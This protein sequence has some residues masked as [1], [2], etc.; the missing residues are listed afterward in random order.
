MLKKMFNS[1]TSII[2]IKSAEDGR[3]V[4]VNPAFTKVIGYTKEEVEGK[5][6]EELNILLDDKYT[7]KML[8]ELQKSGK[9]K[10]AEYKVVIKSGDI[11]D[12]VFSSQ[13]IEYKDE[14]YIITV[15]TDITRQKNIEKEMAYQSRL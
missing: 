7:E 15:M 4:D 14:K 12:V 1:D 9:Y 6:P 11:L 8:I 2:S 3:Y 13:V 5:T 10:D